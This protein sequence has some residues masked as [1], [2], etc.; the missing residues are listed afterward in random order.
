M[1]IIVQKFGGKSVANAERIFNVA[2]IITRT[3]E[4]GENVV[5][6][7]SAQ[8]STTDKLVAKANEINKSASKRELDVL[9]SSGEQISIALLAMAIEKLGYPV[10]SLLGWQ[11]GVFTNAQYSSATLEKIDEN[12]IKKELDKRNIVIVAGFQGINQYQD[13]TTL[14]RG[15]SC[16][17]GWTKCAPSGAGWR[18]P[19]TCAS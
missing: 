12:R 18:R 4:K 16:C 3:Y 11:A 1:G 10:I 2:K 19:S 7:V 14:G 9:L 13:V 5:V 15:G 8:G 17:A 6:V